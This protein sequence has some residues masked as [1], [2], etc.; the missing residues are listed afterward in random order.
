MKKLAVFLIGFYSFSSLAQ[1]SPLNFKFKLSILGGISSPISKFS[2]QDFSQSLYQ[3]NGVFYFG[4]FIKKGNGYAL[5]GDFFAI[6]GQYHL[7]NNFSAGLLFGQSQSKVD[8][9]DALDY[10]KGNWNKDKG[11]HADY[12]VKLI[13]PNIGYRFNVGKLDLGLYQY[14]GL[15]NMNFPFYE[16][17][18]TEIQRSPSWKHELEQK[19]INS[20]VFGWGIDLSIKVRERWSIGISNQFLSGNFNYDM[21]LR[22]V[23][24]GSGSLVFEDVVNYRVINNGLKIGYQF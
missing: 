9:S 13:L 15:G 10:Y 24:G 3:D 21:S 6:Q 19:P 11:N 16:F 20:F 23:P 4:P 22:L 18:Y 14:L 5:R 2:N 17:G 1:E 12:I 7:S 8:L